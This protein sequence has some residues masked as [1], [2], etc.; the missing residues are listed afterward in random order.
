MYNDR[1]A[2]N[3]ADAVRQTLHARRTPAQ[4]ATCDYNPHAAKGL[5]QTDFNNKTFKN[6]LS[7]ILGGWWE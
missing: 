2:I 7:E 1:T 5:E 6:L 4:L 3:P